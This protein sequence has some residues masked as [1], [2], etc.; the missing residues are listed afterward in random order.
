V[1]PFSEEELADRRRP[2]LKRE[3]FRRIAVLIAAPVGLYAVLVLVSLLGGP[4]IGAPLIPLPGG[5]ADATSPVAGQQPGQR[6]TEVFPPIPSGGPT[7]SRPV[8]PS[9][10]L[11]TQLP[12]SV[13]PSTGQSDDQ[14]PASTAEAKAA[15]K[16]SP[17]IGERPGPS[18]PPATKTPPGPTTDPTL[19]PVTPSD[20]PTTPDKPDNPD[21]PKP[22]VADTLIDLLDRLHF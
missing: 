12:S 3:G 14:A 13:E 22:T 17:R 20:P 21:K 10:A 1:K 15:G 19:P 8:P 6:P 18:L 16:P 7:P 5:G 9:S 11:T 4:R 2:W